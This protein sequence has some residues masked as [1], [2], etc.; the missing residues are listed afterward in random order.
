V[1]FLLISG[2]VLITR[3]LTDFAVKAFGLDL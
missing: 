3:D 2:G 1:L